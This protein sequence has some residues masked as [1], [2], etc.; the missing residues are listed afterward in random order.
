MW[1]P[2]ATHDVNKVLREKQIESPPECHAHILFEPKWMIFVV[3]ILP[4]W[5]SI[6]EGRIQ[7]QGDVESLLR[8]CPLDYADPPRHCKPMS[9]SPF[10]DI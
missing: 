9:S 10:S 6:S 5:A 4:R 2:T 8:F 3:H 1:P 7:L